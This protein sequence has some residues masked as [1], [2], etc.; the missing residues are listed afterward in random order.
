MKGPN[1]HTSVHTPGLY[2]EPVRRQV[3]FAKRFSY[4]SGRS[5]VR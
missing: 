1:V 3:V 2:L 4:A 5:A